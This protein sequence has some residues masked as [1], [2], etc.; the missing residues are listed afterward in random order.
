MPEFAISTE[1]ISKVKEL[2]PENLQEIFESKDFIKQIQVQPTE[3]KISINKKNNNRL[4]RRSTEIEMVYLGCLAAMVKDPTHASIEAFWLAC[5][6]QYIHTKLGSSPCASQEQQIEKEIAHFQTLLNHQ[7]EC[8]IPR[9]SLHFEPEKKE[10]DARVRLEERATEK[11]VSSS[12]CN[13]NGIFLHAEWEITEAQLP[14]LITDCHKTALPSSSARLF[15]LGLWNALKAGINFI[16]DQISKF[17]ARRFRTDLF[18]KLNWFRL[19]I[20]RIQRVIDRLAVILPL[21]K[22]LS[23]GCHAA[24]EF[25]RFTLLSWL[26]YLP[27]LFLNIF[28]ALKHIIP[29]SWMPREK[30]ALSWAT[31][32]RSQWSRRRFQL[33][34]DGV[35]FAVNLI[36]TFVKA[37]V[38]MGLTVALYGFDCLNALWDVIDGWIINKN[39]AARVNKSSLSK[40]FKQGIF[41]YG[42]LKQRERKISLIFTIIFFVGM[43]PLFTFL[44]QFLPVILAG[45]IL[46]L[47]TTSIQMAFQYYKT[48]DAARPDF[49]NRVT[50]ITIIKESEHDLILQSRTPSLL[51]SPEGSDDEGE[52][53]ESPAAITPNL[54]D[55][56]LSH[57]DG[58]ENPTPKYPPCRLLFL[59]SARERFYNEEDSA[60]DIQP[61]DVPGCYMKSS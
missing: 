14:L 39:V 24:T 60:F 33:L 59:T 21:F 36:S 3:F 52:P 56:N 8:K 44:P 32:I 20:L 5:I 40:D 23:M 9:L 53:P 57:R 27:R 47:M 18:I 41:E 12:N 42:A 38:G 50:T 58:L 45:A 49:I 61:W 26:F 22:P 31:R 1:Q 29:H 19:F 13:E 11:N 2:L 55:V 34:N 7:Y 6:L 30:A 17:P 10:K 43:I 46:I 16:V 25:L 15:F 28:L 4:S 35:W 51:S 54:S 37:S 48:F